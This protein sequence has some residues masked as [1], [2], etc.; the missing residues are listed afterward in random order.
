MIEPVGNTEWIE[1]N[2]EHDSH[3]KKSVKIKC[4]DKMVLRN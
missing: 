2:A 3:L 1:Q 4:Y